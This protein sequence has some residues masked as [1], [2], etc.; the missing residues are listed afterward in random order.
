M[1]IINL[2]FDSELEWLKRQWRSISVHLKKWKK[3]I[4]TNL[5]SPSPSI[6]K[7]F[8]YAVLPWCEGKAMKILLIGIPVILYYKNTE[9]S[10]FDMGKKDESLVNVT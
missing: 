2:L 9:S 3:R 5:K 4:A 6:V 7:L 1:V 10:S 8:I